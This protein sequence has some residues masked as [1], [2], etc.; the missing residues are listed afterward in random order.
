MVDEAG[1]LIPGT[2]NAL[3]LKS[4]SGGPLHGYGIVRWIQ[5]QTHD[6]LRVEEGVLYPALHRLQR[7]GLLEAEWGIN[8]TGRRAKFYSITARG[9]R[10]L[11]REIASWRRRAGAVTGL[12]EG[13]TGSGR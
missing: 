7:D 11:E 6:V 8:D 4:V 1:K 13:D 10:T 9:R 2:L 5:E 12:L 3:V